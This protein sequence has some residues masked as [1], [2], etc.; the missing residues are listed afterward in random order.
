MESTAKAAKVQKLLAEFGSVLVALS[1]G[2]DSSLLLKLAVDAL[3]PSRVLAVTARS[4]STTAEEIEMA[5]CVA[6]ICG[7]AHRVVS[8]SDLE[9]PE[10]AANPPDRC[11][12]CQRNRFRLL[13]NI[14]ENE[15]INIVVDGSNQSDQG[16]YRPGRRALT[17]LAVR[18]PFKE[19]G[20]TKDDIRQLSRAL[21]LPNW[22]RPANACLAS[23][24]PYGT[25][26]T[27][28]DLSRVADGE[29]LILSLGLTQC[30]LRHHGAIARIEVPLKECPVLLEPGINK[31]LV[32]GIKQLGYTY[33]TLDLQG[34]RTGSLN[35][36]ITA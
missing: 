35:E 32:D 18:S 10:I 25:P 3:G 1:G 27:A 14:A 31:K 33:V 4:E 23:R 29:K 7:A 12:H 6:G 21:G 16:D 20:L 2:V 15:G 13:C 26:I 9:I 5:A 24:F 8:V 17:E 22:N 30:R 19:C 36:V 34:Y 11:Y 28:A